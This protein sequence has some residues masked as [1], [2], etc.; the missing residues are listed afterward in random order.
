MSVRLFIAVWPP[1]EVVE[2]LEKMPRPQIA[3]VRWTTPEQWHVT[4]CF[5]GRVEEP[6]EVLAA[7]KRTFGKGKAEGGNSEGYVA[8]LGPATSWW[9]RRLLQLPVEGLSELA[10]ATIRATAGMGREAEERPFVGHLTL[11]RAKRPL[12]V[13]DSLGGFR[14]SSSW[15]VTE[16]VVASSLTLPEG[17]RYERLAT[18][19]LQ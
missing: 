12:A 17:A 2:L 6:E 4:L 5:L 3:G 9:G 16:V 13:L 1:L 11:A 8:R 15:K 14:V 18:V 19:P 10:A 7:V